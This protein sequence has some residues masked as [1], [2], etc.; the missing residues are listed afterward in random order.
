MCGKIF[1]IIIIM[2]KSSKSCV[3]ANGLV[4]DNFTCPMGVRQGEKISPL[5]VSL[6]LNDLF[7]QSSH[8]NLQMVHNLAD[9]VDENIE[10]FLKQYLLW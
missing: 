6:F 5:L 2:Y 8:V 9:A 4:S 1:N 7:L 3:A 10:M